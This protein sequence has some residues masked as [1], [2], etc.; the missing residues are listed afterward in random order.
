MKTYRM[1]VTA[2]VEV[3]AE[4]AVQAKAFAKQ[5]TQL[6]GDRINTTREGD[7]PSV[8]RTLRTFPVAIG[9]PALVQ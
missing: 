5:H 9:R 2:V 7:Q 4:N 1:T 6:T 3:Q 8:R